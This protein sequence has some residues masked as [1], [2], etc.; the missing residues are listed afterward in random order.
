L[1]VI[2][3]FSSLSFVLEEFANTMAVRTGGLKGI[4]KLIASKKMGTIELNTGIQISGTFTTVINYGHTP[5]YFQTNGSTAL[6]IE[7][8]E[9]I[10]H[11]IEQHPNGYGSTLGK[12]EGINTA[13]EDMSPKDLEVYGII[14][15]KS[16]SLNF[17]GGIKVEGEII[18]GK[19]DL[20][21]KIILISLKNCLVTHNETV[22]FDPS[23]GVYDMAIGNHIASAFAGP[24]DSNSFEDIYSISKQKT[25][26]II[27]SDQ[28]KKVHELYETVKTYRT[29]NTDAVEIL[30]S[31]FK[32]LIDKH[33]SEWLLLLELYEL[34][35]NKDLSLMNKIHEQLLILKQ[36]KHYSKLITDGLHLIIKK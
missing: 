23:W 8:T 15:G 29:N 3:N 5:I 7:G 36:N 4:Q 24:A 6:A 22:L 35:Y 33:P 32:E 11:G 20:Q 34:V 17:V 2:P 18:T 30:K 28:E 16:T 13:I 14:E 19:R 26:P 9:L 10:G 21:G 31:I 27:Y 1:F 25:T 12:L